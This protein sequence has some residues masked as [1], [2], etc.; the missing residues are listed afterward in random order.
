MNFDAS[1]LC[2]LP[3]PPSVLPLPAIP[4]RKVKG[5]TWKILVTRTSGVAVIIRATP[6]PARTRFNVASTRP[7]KRRLHSQVGPAVTRENQRR[8]EEDTKKKK[9]KTLPD[10]GFRCAIS[11]F[12]NNKPTTKRRQTHTHTQSDFSLSL[13]FLLHFPLL[14][15][16]RLNS[17]EYQQ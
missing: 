6:F 9:K 7:I 14:L 13:S 11:A 5:Q 3:S 2:P 8:G 10:S 1:A 12:L 4:N 15:S 16:T 17:I